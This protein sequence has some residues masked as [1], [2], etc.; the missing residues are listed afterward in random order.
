MRV[1]YFGARQTKR[2]TTVRIKRGGGRKLIQ[3][4]F[5]ATMPS[6]LIQVWVRYGERQTAR[7]GRYA[8]QKR[9]RIRQLFTISPGKMFEIEGE[10]VF[11]RMV[12]DEAGPMFKKELDFYLG[13]V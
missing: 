5:I 8:G 6:G 13:K 11:K 3:S 9:Q 12:E 2:G 1:Y 7:G 10:Q 4:A